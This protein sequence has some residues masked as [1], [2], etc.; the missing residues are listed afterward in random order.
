MVKRIGW[1]EPVVA[2]VKVVAFLFLGASLTAQP[3]TPPT[4][5]E[6]NGP[7]QSVGPHA[8]GTAHPV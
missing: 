2:A 1:T 8:A 5:G 3:A 4:G 6:A 7:G